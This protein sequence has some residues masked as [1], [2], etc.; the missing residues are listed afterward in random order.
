MEARVS[1]G[2]GPPFHHA[3]NRAPVEEAGTVAEGES[4]H[5]AEFLTSSATNPTASERPNRLVG[6]A[7]GPLGLCTKTVTTLYPSQVSPWSD[8]ES[9]D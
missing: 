3:T 8:V 7:Q 6:R 1:V 5:L 2:R 4:Q 9:G